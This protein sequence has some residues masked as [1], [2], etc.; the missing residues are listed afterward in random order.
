MKPSESGEPKSTGSQPS[1]AERAYEYIRDRILHGEY[2]S[3]DYIEEEPVSAVIGVSRTPIREALRRLAAEGFMELI[4]RRGARVRGVTPQELRQFL[5]A[6]F[7]IES[8][9]IRMIC[10][11]K[12]AIPAGLAHLIGEISRLVMEQKF[13]EA[14]EL[15]RQFHRSIVGLAGNDL[16]VELFDMLRFRYLLAMQST[17]PDPQLVRAVVDE[18]V[19]L[20]AALSAYDAA[21]A[22]K[23]LAAHLDPEHAPRFHV[24]A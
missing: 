15:D 7:A 17:P 3:G 11:R 19:E 14:A 18:H 2:T 1:A 16:M 10:T 9:C 13:F 20:L 4:P 5:E 12:P 8:H 23:L 22:I 6:R 24:A 21:Q